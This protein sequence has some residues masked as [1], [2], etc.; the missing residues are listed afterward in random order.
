VLVAEKLAERLHVSVG[1]KLRVMAQR[2]D[3]EVGAELFR[4]RGIL[5]AVSPGISRTQV[6]VTLAAARRL[7]GLGDV[8]HQIV[9]QLPN[10][11]MAD[12]VANDARAVAGPGVEVL[13]WGQL[14]PILKQLDKLIG[15]Y[16]TILA[17]F[18]YLLVGLGILNTMLMSI[19]ERTHELGVL[20]ALGT[21]P[22]SIISMLLAESF[23]IATLAAVIGLGIGV[24]L[25]WWGQ[26]H[27]LLDYTSSM[28]EGI[29]MGGSTMRAALH[30]QLSLPSVFQATFIVYAVTVL[31]GLWPAR[32]IS[33]LQP[34]SALR[35]S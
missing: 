29:E 5:H 16:Q 2:T 27:V 1:Q 20:Q 18:V 13:T 22:R 7:L 23:W 19:L 17:L 21:R 15:G 14:L 4:V 26:G 33:K 30:T 32:H 3:G 28:G 35:A 31:A 6:V 11:E 10:A 12:A 34:A 25:V 9:V 8:V 24:P